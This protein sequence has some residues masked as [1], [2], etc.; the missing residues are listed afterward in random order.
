MTVIIFNHSTVSTIVF[1]IPMSASREQASIGR[2]GIVLF[3]RRGF[4]TLRYYVFSN[5]QKDSDLIRIDSDTNLT[6]V[7][8]ECDTCSVSGSTPFLVGLSS[9]LHLSK[10]QTRLYR[11]IHA[12][13]TAKDINNDALDRHRPP[14][15]LMAICMSHWT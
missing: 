7:S 9:A 3:P 8:V 15:P 10:I 6:G 4:D 13:P 5:S 1:S 11:M 2:L 12:T 14:F